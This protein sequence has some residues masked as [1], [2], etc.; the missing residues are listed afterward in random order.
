MITIGSTWATSHPT[1]ADACEHAYRMLNG[2][3]I[4]TSDELL[5]PVE[6]TPI[7]PD[8]VVT[9]LGHTVMRYSAYAHFANRM[10]MRFDVLD[11]SPAD[12][13]RPTSTDVDGALH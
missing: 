9:V 10:I 8:R 11:N 7:E 4:R 13:K 12:G 6:V 1:W 2:S 3:A 5:H